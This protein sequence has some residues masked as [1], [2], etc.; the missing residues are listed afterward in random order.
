MTDT[1]EALID[2]IRKQRAPLESLSERFRKW[3]EQREAFS[4]TDSNKK[5]GDFWKM[6]VWGDSL[7]RI[8]LLL[9]QNFNYIETIGILAVSRYLFELTVWLKLLQADSRYGLVYHCELLKNQQDFYEALQ[10]NAEREI[11]FLQQVEKSE[12][13]LLKSTTQE[14]LQIPD[15]EARKIAAR[16][17]WS[18]VSQQIDQDAAR[19]FSLYAEQARSNGYGYQASLIEAKALPK[20]HKAIEDIKRELDIFRCDL[21]DEVKKLLKERWNWKQQAIKVGM[22]EEY[23][24][25]YT[26]ASLLMHAT[27]ASITTDQKNLE[28]TE[29]KAFLKYIRVRLLDIIEMAEEPL[30]NNPA[31]VQ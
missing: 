5:S 27:P 7:V 21:S 14:V 26:Y 3:I 15:E 28:P 30:S 16:Q 9:E 20:H 19:R 23:E 13:A 25:I 4:H 24:F 18:K 6:C 8:R 22:G 29:I 31:V 2:D 11:S 17:I 1:F 12:S 10:R